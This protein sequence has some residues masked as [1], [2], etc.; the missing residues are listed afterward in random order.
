MV[1]IMPGIENFAPERTDTSS[2][3]FDVTELVADG[4][5]ELLDV[6]EHLR[7]DGGRHLAPFGVVGAA[8]VRRNREAR[9]DRQAGVGHLGEV[10]ALAA[11]RVLHRPVAVGLARAEEVDVF[12][13]LRAR[14]RRTLRSRLRRGLA[15]RLP[16]SRLRGLLGGTLRS[17][18]GGCLLLRCLL[19]GHER[20]FS[21]VPSASVTC[22]RPPW[23]LECSGRSGVSRCRARRRPRKCR[24]A[25]LP[26]RA[27]S[28]AARA[29]GRAP[30]RRRA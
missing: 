21:R 16:G 22:E 17:R 2:G 19:L 29:G 26:G 3:F 11:E 8:R 13:R 12:P 28:P 20:V 18:R 4:L 15:A 24:R 7:L 14:L 30:P 9:G 23:P 27:G 5:L 6:L 25:P 10:G 1:S